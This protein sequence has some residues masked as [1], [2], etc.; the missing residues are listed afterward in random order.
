MPGDDQ[1]NA[2]AD[3]SA[4]ELARLHDLN[5]A[6]GPV[7]FGTDERTLGQRLAERRHQVI[8]AITR[9]DSLLHRVHCECYE[10]KGTDYSP[11][12]IEYFSA[13]MQ[14][15]L[16]EVAQRAAH[17]QPSSKAAELSDLLDVLADSNLIAFFCHPQNES[18]IRQGI[19]LQT[20][21]SLQLSP[22]TN[23]AAALTST[24]LRE[25]GKVAAE[26]PS[27]A[28]ARAFSLLHELYGRNFLHIWER[29]AVSAD[30]NLGQ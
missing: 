3:R 27:V 2:V 14:G 4:A 6:P 18:E 7:L 25:I 5:A 20:E 21:K 30:K 11:G 26:S 8:K 1:R 28:C 10:L 22:E 9:P 15:L 24:L 13:I 17:L 12:P 16:L 29:G 23:E 19:G